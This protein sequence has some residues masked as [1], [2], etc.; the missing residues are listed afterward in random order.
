VTALKV[1]DDLID[2]GRVAEAA[3]IARTVLST[4]PHNAEALCTLARCHDMRNEHAETLAAATA[5]VTAEPDNEWAHRLRSVALRKL[6]RVPEA[7][8]AADRAVALAPHWRLT[9]KCRASALLAAGRMAEAYQAAVR[10]RALA[11][12]E[13]DTFYLFTDVYEAAG[14]LA[15]ARR[16]YEAGLRLAPDNVSLLAGLAY[17]ERLSHRD[18]AAARQ[19][20]AVLRIQPAST[21]YRTALAYAMHRM[22]RRLSLVGAFFAVAVAGLYLSGVGAPWRAAVAVPLLVGYAALVRR[23]HRGLGRI[24]RTHWKLRGAE[25]PGV[26]AAPIGV[27]MPVLLMVW[28]GL[29]PL[30]LDPVPLALALVA[31][32]VLF[33]AA[34]PV[35]SADLHESRG[36]RRRRAEFRRALAAGAPG[37]GAPATGAP[38]TG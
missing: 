14:D 5:A 32:L 30:S 13:P 7:L 2:I 27:A 22:Q 16:E 33:L 28:A 3:D 20:L 36:Q 8:A 35:M 10:V 34:V 9:Y 17:L 6:G 21:H 12:H 24:A 1:A 26:I 4:A 25:R 15:A 31:Q 29:A 37:A 38:G 19:Y 11:P 18:G 23:A